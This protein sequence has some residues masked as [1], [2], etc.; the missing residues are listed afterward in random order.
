MTSTPRSRSNHLADELFAL[1]AARGYAAYG[2]DVTTTQHSLEAAHFARLASASPALVVAAL[3]HDIGHLL[4]AVPDA[5]AAWHDDA[6]HEEVGARWL[7]RHFGPEIVEPVRLHVPAKRYLCAM[8]PEYVA[9]LSAASIH[10]LELQGGPMSAAEAAR[11]E[12]EPFHDA[13]IA[14]RRWDDRGKVAGL[15][16]APLESYRDTIGGLARASTG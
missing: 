9:T 7:E 4:D 2:E 16:V 11:F 6:H 15:D 10:T 14:L 8:E 5:I 1:Y 12:R 3:L 13:A